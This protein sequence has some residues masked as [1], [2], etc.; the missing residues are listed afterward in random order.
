MGATNNLDKV[1]KNI[2]YQINNV[3]FNIKV[4]GIISLDA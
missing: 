2:R 4:V 1:Y 3:D